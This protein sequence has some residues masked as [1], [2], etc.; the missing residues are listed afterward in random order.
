ML[1]LLQEFNITILDRLGKHNAIADF[2]SRIQNENNDQAVEDKFPVVYV[3]AVSTKSPWYSY[4]A[5]YFATGKIPFHLTPREK[6]K[7]VHHSTS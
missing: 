1:L 4:I 5:N 2:L 3:F 6:R 7:I